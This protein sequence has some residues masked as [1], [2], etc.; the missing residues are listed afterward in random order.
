MVDV[1]AVADDPVSA[2]MPWAEGLTQVLFAFARQGGDTVVFPMLSFSHLKGSEDLGVLS[3]SAGQ[4]GRSCERGP[5][6]RGRRSLC[7]PHASIS[8]E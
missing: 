1:F 4:A 6:E 7:S 2:I 8:W 5:A 3:G